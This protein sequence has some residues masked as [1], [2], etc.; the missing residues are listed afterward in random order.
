[1]VR[2]LTILILSLFVYFNNA[3]K[4]ISISPTEIEKSFSSKIEDHFLLLEAIPNNVTNNLMLYIGYIHEE[5]DR[6]LPGHSYRYCKN[7]QNLI[8]RDWIYQ[9]NFYYSCCS[10]VISCN[11]SKCLYECPIPPANIDPD[12]FRTFNYDINRIFIREVNSESKWIDTKIKFTYTIPHNFEGFVRKFIILFLIIS[13]IF[14]TINNLTS[15]INFSANTYPVVT[16]IIH[17]ISTFTTISF[18]AILLSSLEEFNDIAS[19]SSKAALSFSILT[20]IYSLFLIYIPNKKDNINAT[21]KEQRIK[22]NNKSCFAKYIK[23]LKNSQS[24]TFF[25]LLFVGL[26]CYQTWTNYIFMNMFKEYFDVEWEILVIVIIWKSMLTIFF[27]VAFFTAVYEVKIPIHFDK[28]TGEMAHFYPTEG[29]A[30]KL[31]N[32]II[33]NNTNNYIAGFCDQDE[34]IKF[35]EYKLKSNE[36]Y[37]ID[38][39]VNNNTNPYSYIFWKIGNIK[40]NNIILDDKV[41]ISKKNKGF[42][43]KKYGIIKLTDRDIYNTLNVYNTVKTSDNKYKFI[44]FGVIK[45][46]YLHQNSHIFI[47]TIAI[48]F[49]ILPDYSEDYEYNIIENLRNEFHKLTKYMGRSYGILYWIIFGITTLCFII[50]EIYNFYNFLNIILIFVMICFSLIVNTKITYIPKLRKQKNYK[51]LL[52]HSQNKKKRGI[53]N[54]SK[55]NFSHDWM[56]SHNHNIIKDFNNMKI[57][58]YPDLK[59]TILKQDTTKN[60]YYEIKINNNVDI[61]GFGISNGENSDIFKILNPGFW[62]ST[63]NKKFG[64]SFKNEIEW[65][66]ASNQKNMTIGCGYL[67]NKLFFI[68]PDKECYCFDFNMGNL[69][70]CTSI[71]SD[72]EIKSYDI[73]LKRE[74]KIL[75]LPEINYDFSKQ[76]C[77]KNNDE[78]LI[79]N[80]N[81][82]NNIKISHLQTNSY[83]S[84]LIEGNRIGVERSSQNIGRI[85]F[86]IIFHELFCYKNNPIEISIK[87]DISNCKKPDFIA[88]GLVEEKSLSQSSDVN[89]IPGSEGFDSIGYHSDDGSI[90]ISNNVVGTNN[91]LSWYNSN[92]FETLFEIKLGFDGST[93]YF[94]N[95]YNERF[96][97][98]EINEIEL[99]KNGNN[100]YPVIYFHGSEM[101]NMTLKCYI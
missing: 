78:I 63:E 71:S 18:E 62:C 101:K 35:S 43:N 10:K 33:P 64:F 69:V 34:I 11:N 67:H 22:I 73:N 58:N 28:D 48:I 76:I 81:W 97:I 52:Q 2:I 60:F 12:P 87:I 30:Q 68:T 92:T 49:R 44:D 99:W 100:F 42:F 50:N 66:D 59:W 3:T 6:V 38:N 27:L 36:L 4:L 56:L 46:G 45:N 98:N 20:S 88:L 24:K 8:V 32:R 47:Q 31:I 40:G 79:E 72:L 86:N 37:V 39:D 96:T 95:P 77:I 91:N 29:K 7:N 70:I 61:L 17:F 5:H 90:C 25:S 26:I 74:N 53:E 15:A 84:F 21:E 16:T 1:M 83:K 13:I 94:V 80:S 85:G 82:S 89:L 23:F 54:L 19:N 9:E 14:F 93:L 57:S 41:L 75:Y 55:Y 51:N 65:I